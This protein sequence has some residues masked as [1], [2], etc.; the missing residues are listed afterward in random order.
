MSFCVNISSKEFK[1]TAKRLDISEASLENIVHSY[2]NTEGNEGTF[3]S[4]SYILSR[5]E[6]TP[7]TEISENGL[8]LIEKKYSQPITVNTYEDA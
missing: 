6:G 1:D 5:V 8:K 2:M 4:D 3:P 7:I